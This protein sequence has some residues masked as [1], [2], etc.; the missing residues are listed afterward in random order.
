VHVLIDTL[1]VV[2]ESAHGQFDEEVVVHP[3]WPTSWDAA[4]N[5]DAQE[6]H[7]S[8]DPRCCLVAKVL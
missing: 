4:G 7:V 1:V 6:L 3:G 2:E 5:N 8:Q